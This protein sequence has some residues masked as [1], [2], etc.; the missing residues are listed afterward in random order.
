MIVGGKLDACDTS[1]SVDSIITCR[2]NGDKLEKKNENQ[3]INW[4]WYLNRKCKK[5]KE[6]VVNL[7]SSIDSIKCRF[8][9]RIVL[10]LLNDNYTRLTSSFDY[11]KYIDCF[12]VGY[13]SYCWRLLLLSLWTYPHLTNDDLNCMCAP[14]DVQTP[15]YYALCVNNCRTF[16][17]MP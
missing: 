3:W 10:N 4:I 12:A 5:S 8:I 9:F 2:R 7:F 6:K 14:N 17:C 15:N 1:E 16:P 13:S 11:V